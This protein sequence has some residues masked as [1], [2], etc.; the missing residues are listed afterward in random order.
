MGNIKATPKK[1]GKRIRS[2]SGSMQFVTTKALS[3]EVTGPSGNSYIFM[4]DSPVEVTDKMDISSFMSNRNLC[5]F[6]SEQATFSRTPVT[7]KFPSVT[8]ISGLMTE[9]QLD[10]SLNRRDI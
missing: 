5:I 8:K 4:K 2:E 1:Q 3:L 7:K 10:H 9:D 6:G